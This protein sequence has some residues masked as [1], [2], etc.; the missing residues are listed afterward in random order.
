MNDPSEWD[1]SVHRL[2]FIFGEYCFYNVWFEAAELRTHFI[3]LSGSLDDSSAAAAPLLGRHRALAIPAHP[4]A[5]EPGWLKITRD[6]LRYV[7]ASTTCYFIEPGNSF[8]AYL[9]RMPNKHRHE[10]FRKLRRVAEHCE[11]AID[12]RCYRSVTEARAF[13]ALASTVSRKTYQ[14][15]L[16]DVGL[17][18][19]AAFEAQLLAR[20][21]QDRMRGYLLFHRDTPVAYGY[22]IVTGDCLRFQ[23]IGYDPAYR[24]WSAGNVLIAEALRSAIGESRFAIIDFGSG[25]AQ[26]KRSF[27]TGSRRCATVFLFRPTARRLLTLAAHRTCIALSDICAGIA[28]RLGLKERLKRRFRT[29]AAALLGSGL[30]LLLTLG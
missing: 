12:V 5:A 8:D 23:Y 18:E 29:P 9:Q 22:C 27:A 1:D 11:G 16:L 28:D 2:K 15:R 3:R 20:A 30:A 24:H 25:E 21:G 4:I 26:Y 14:R 6:Y 17:P 19:T 13:Y 10:L 7:P